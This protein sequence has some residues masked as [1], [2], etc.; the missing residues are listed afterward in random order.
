[1]AHYKAF[2]FIVLC[3]LMSACS[4]MQPPSQTATDPSPRVE[5]AAQAGN[6]TDLAENLPLTKIGNTT[7]SNNTSGA[8]DQA[9]T[10]IW[11]RMRQGFGLPEETAPA[12]DQQLRWYAKNQDYLDRVFSRA[13]PYLVYILGEIESRGI[14]TEI[15]LL[16]VVES[17]YDPFAYSHGRAS[18]LWQF[19]PGTGK[20]YGLKQ[21]WWIDG[22]RDVIASTEAALDHLE[23]LHRQFKG[24][25]LLAL[26]AYNS[27]GGKVSRAIRQNH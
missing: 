20:I 8:S 11:T 13:E 22:R 7:E 12:I 6:E 24:D 5:D 14:P 15:A 16:P 1:M 27:G 17:A 10:D 9:E 26:A 25:W 2:T 4:T 3:L 18:G 21:D 19:I 23:K